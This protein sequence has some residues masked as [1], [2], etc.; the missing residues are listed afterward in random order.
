MKSIIA[1]VIIFIAVGI[2]VYSAVSF[3][4]FLKGGALDVLSQT[5]QDVLMYSLAQLTS[6]WGGSPITPKTP[7]SVINET[8][9]SN[10]TPTSTPKPFPRQVG[11][12][13]SVSQYTSN[14]LPKEQLSPLPAIIVDTN[15]ISGP[16]D[17][18]IIEET[19]EVTFKFE[20]NVFP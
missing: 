10:L 19:T 6:F 1:Y 8:A 18:A 20:A 14:Q 12:A 13:S 4:L 15:I 7:S 9:I 3:T 17:G 16:A 2:L 11:S 5:S